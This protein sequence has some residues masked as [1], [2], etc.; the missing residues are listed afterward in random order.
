MISEPASV[1]QKLRF[2]AACCDFVKNALK[3]VDDA[4][5]YGSMT[6]VTEPEERPSNV[7]TISEGANV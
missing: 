1:P 6:I 2:L 4:F 3:T 7:R 5:K